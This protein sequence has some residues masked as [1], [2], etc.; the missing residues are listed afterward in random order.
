[1]PP[2]CRTRAPSTSH[3]GR[4][5]PELEPPLVIKP[6]FGSWGADVVRCDDGRGD[7]GG[8]RRARRQARGST[9]PG[10]SRRSSSPRAA[11]TSASSSPAVPSS[12][13]CDAWRRP[14]S[15][16]RTSHSVRAESRSTRRTRHARSRSPP[17][18]PSA[19]T[20]W[21][22]TSLPADVGTW[23]VLEVNGAVDF[24]AHVLARRR[25]VRRRP[26]RALGAH[27]A[28]A[29][30]CR[31]RGRTCGRAGPPARTGAGAGT[32]RTSGRRGRGAAPP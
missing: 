4:T 32:V 14:A 12:G 18:R 11:S 23:V 17:P 10:R 25:R 30:R 29:S 22:S 26:H 19:A 7:R 31:T 3:P 8:G 1:M 5:L 15:G 2:R 28:G 24:N 21:A 16:A 6:R 9:R 13:R 20:S 27:G